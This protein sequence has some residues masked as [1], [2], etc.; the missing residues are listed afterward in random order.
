MVAVEGFRGRVS[1]EDEV[2]IAWSTLLSDFHQHLPL[3]MKLSHKAVTVTI[4]VVH[5]VIIVIISSASPLFIG[6]L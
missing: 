6:F 2:L 1:E 3:L 5:T 4:V